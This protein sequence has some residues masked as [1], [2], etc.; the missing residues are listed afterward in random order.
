MKQK[1]KPFFLIQ[2]PHVTRRLLRETRCL[3]NLFYARKKK[4]E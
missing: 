4:N 2:M 3:N 1:N